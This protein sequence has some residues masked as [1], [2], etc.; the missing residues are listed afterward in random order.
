MS[1]DLKDFPYTPTAAN[2][3]EV[4]VEEDGEGQE[5]VGEAGAA[6]SLVKLMQGNKQ[7]AV[8]RRRGGGGEAVAR[9]R[10]RAGGGWRSKLAWLSAETCRGRVDGV[11]TRPRRRDAVFMITRESCRDGVV[12]TQARTSKRGSRIWI[13]PVPNWR[14]PKNNSNYN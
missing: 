5:A 13:E 4:G 6:N 14:R 8:R 10:R 12:P 11:V 1:K 9:R 7:E 3:P 2:T